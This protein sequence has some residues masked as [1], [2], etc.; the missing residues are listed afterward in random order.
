MSC[1]LLTLLMLLTDRLKSSQEDIN[2][3]VD[4]CADSEKSAVK[5]ATLKCI[6]DAGKNC[7]CQCKKTSKQC[8][9]NASDYTWECRCSRII[10]DRW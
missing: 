1:I 8:G 6:E 4:V 10:S 2:F 3:K 5:K 9:D 7:H